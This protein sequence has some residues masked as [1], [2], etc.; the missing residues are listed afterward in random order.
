[1]EIAVPVE[2][3]L[4]AE[5]ETNLNETLNRLLGT[6]A[7]RRWWVFL[8]TLI[9]PLAT[10]VVLSRIPN[11]YTSEATLLVVQQQIPQRYVL[12][13]TTTDI[14]EALQA[15][16][17]EVLSRTRLLEIID[18]FGLYAKERKRLSPEGLLEVMR[19]DIGILPLEVQSAQKDINSFKIS[20]IADKPQLA[21]AVT[22]KLTALFIEQN[23]V[24]REHQATTTTNFLREQLDTTKSKLAAAEAQVRSFKMQNLGE[25]PEQQQGN[26]AI[27]S[28]LQ[29]QLQSAMTSL[30]RAQE[31]REY[32]KSLAGYRAL[33]IE[34][35][36]ARLRSER[37]ALLT[38]YTPE[39]SAVVKINEKI[40]QTET[41]LRTLRE[42][43]SPGTAKAQAEPL[44]LMGNDQDPSIA[45]QLKSQLEANR[46]E[47]ENLS[48]EE[49]KLKAAIEQYQKRLNQT[50]VREQQLAGILR[51]YEQL[52]L[53]YT[54]LLNK[55]S[56]SRMAAD[57]EKRQEGQQFRLV[58]Q[59]SLPTVP[60]SPN[61]IK[62]SLG[63]V[64]GG[65]AFGLGLGF[66]ANFRDRSFRSEKD[67]SPRFALPILVSVPLIL[68]PREQQGRAW[69]RT[70]EWAAG[71]GL[72]LLVLAAEVYEYYL[73]RHG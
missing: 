32:L 66:L 18:E 26:L 69:K 21:Q 72:V 38:T 62:I 14:R 60:S 63:G 7:R 20:F 61:R 34:G 22:S 16:T 28:G 49:L 5:P 68:T 2:P 31:Q 36:L 29:S 39:Y 52:K 13:T 71:S 19:H 27:L 11:H 33:T 47:I 65:I 25:L 4:L 50:P 8:P 42:S 51:N 67:L 6:I 30:S 46:L 64:A 45:L 3:K 70:V 37:A 35:D 57:L 41:L 17:Q 56:Q 15:T 44:S 58:D 24:T 43:P 23:L 55:E 59:P 73:Y 10:L 1:L 53:D 12:P 54:D 48:A 40:A 9:T